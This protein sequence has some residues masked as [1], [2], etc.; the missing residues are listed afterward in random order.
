MP[1][2]FINHNSLL[3]DAVRKRIRSHAAS[4]KNKGKTIT[5]PSRKNAL[6]IT[7]TSFRIPNIIDNASKAAENRFNLERRI[8][9]GLYFQALLPGESKGLVVKRDVIGSLFRAP[10]RFSS[11]LSNALDY[12]GL[13][14]PI[15]V[16]Y[17]FDDE[18][19]KT[20]FERPIACPDV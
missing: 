3:N 16:Q 5:R 17:M 12:N 20:A 8:D 9:D 18:A 19:C 2:E 1:L 11:E 4:G 10:I 13:S 6:A 15:C 7:T 14:T